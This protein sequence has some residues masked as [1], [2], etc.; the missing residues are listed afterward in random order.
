MFVFFTYGFAQWTFR[1]DQFH[2]NKNEVYLTTFF[3]DRDGSVHENGMAPR[4]L[5]EMLKQDF[6]HV[7]NYCR[8]EKSQAV[9]KYENNIFHERIWYVDPSFLEMFSFPLKWGLSGSLKDANSI[10]LSE[11]MS[12]KYFGNENPV[13]QNLVMKFGEGQGKIFC[14][15]W[16]TS[17][18]STV[19]FFILRFSHQF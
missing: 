18:A 17:N 3:A 7:E 19:L 13:G 6:V 12:V 9:L 16:S 4:P 10:I 2:E 15:F 14:Y 5:G 11:E 8:I 1:T